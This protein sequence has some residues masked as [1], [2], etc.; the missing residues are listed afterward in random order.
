MGNGR[1]S[2]STYQSRARARG[3][4]DAF[5]YSRQSKTVHPTLDPQGLTVRESRDSAEH[6]ESNSIIVGL[7]VSG[8]MGAVIRAIHADLPQLHELLLGH[9]Y[10]P[11]PQIMFSGFCNGTNTSVPPLQIGQFE[12]D[13]RMDQ[14]LE[15]L[16]LGG[17]GPRESAELMMFVAA[18][19]TSIDCWEKRGKRGYMFLIGDEPA[20]LEVKAN[21]VNT[22]I[23]SGIQTNIPLEDI[24]DEVK[25]RYN[26][27]MIIPVGAYGGDDPALYAFWEQY[28]GSQYVIRLEKP[29]D[30]AET[31]ALTIGLSEGTIGMNDGADHLR[32][33]GASSDTIDTVTKALAAVT[34]SSGGSSVVKGSGGSLTGLTAPDDD[35]GDKRTRRL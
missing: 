5:A 25:E 22:F 1:W 7:D 21:E 31:I 15:N 23:G 11:H 12:S 35:K 19:H 8:S 6:P 33:V 26:L 30:V 18:R 29:D 27:Y 28:L 4:Q 14:N 13:N 16:I 3:G 17:G 24:V 32:A 20:F 9:N 2:T 34:K 10:I